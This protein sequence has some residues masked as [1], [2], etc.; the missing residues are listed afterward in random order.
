M[1]FRHDRSPLTPLAAHGRTFQ[2]DTKLA[3][4]ERESQFTSALHGCRQISPLS[5]FIFP[6]L[7]TF[8][9]PIPDEL[10]GAESLCTGVVRRNHVEAIAGCGF[11]ASEVERAPASA[12]FA[13]R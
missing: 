8:T 4:V 3:Q 13:D 2:Y 9:R 10:S 12:L 1:R 11:A 6:A 5:R 7:R